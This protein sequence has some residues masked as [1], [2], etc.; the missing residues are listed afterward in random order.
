LFIRPATALAINAGCSAALIS[1]FCQKFGREGVRLAWPIPVLLALTVLHHVYLLARIACA[2][3]TQPSVPAWWFT[4]ALHGLARTLYKEGMMILALFYVLML[5]VLQVGDA[6]KFWQWGVSETVA[7]SCYGCITAT[8][9][10]AFFHGRKMRMAEARA[11]CTQDGHQWAC[12]R[13][14]CFHERPHVQQT[15]TTPELEKAE[16]A[17]A[18]GDMIDEKVCQR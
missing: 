16:K 13:M 3:R 14:L 7:A 17:V 4:P 12:S 10:L 9:V 1:W 11:Q 2:A 15:A 6:W 5:A 18:S 8:S